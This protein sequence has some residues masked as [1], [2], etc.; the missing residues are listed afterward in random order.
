MEPIHEGGNVMPSPPLPIP[1]VTYRSP[2]SAPSVL[3]DLMYLSVLAEQQIS[4]TSLQS[5][6]SGQILAP[7]RA[8]I[9]PGLFGS[10]PLANLYFYDCG[11]QHLHITGTANVYE[12]AGEILVS[13]LVPFSGIPGLVNA[14]FSV[15]AFRTLQ[16]ALPLIDPTKPLV[17][18]GHSLGGAV[19]QILG[20]FLAQGG[21][22]VSSII[23]LGSPKVGNVTFAAAVS[24]LPVNRYE[25]VGDIVPSV[26][27]FMP[28]PIPGLYAMPVNATWGDYVHGGNPLTVDSLG[29]VTN[30][31]IEMGPAAISLA[32]AAGTIDLHYAYS[33]SAYAKAGWASLPNYAPFAQGYEKPYTMAGLVQPPQPPNT[34]VGPEIAVPA[35]F[36]NKFT[37]QNMSSSG[38]IVTLGTVDDPPPPSYVPPI[39]PI[40]AEDEGCNC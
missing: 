13:Q 16:K 3:A 4:G 14:F 39:I 2:L 31:H 25:L 38:Q 11:P 15:I 34:V 8:V 26:P 20:V 40:P 10:I 35:C 5:A 17:L 23:T 1:G 21:F 9:I 6:L 22:D 32:L 12:L 36:T 37:V 33:Y 28:L 30:E 7:G 19:A 18:S 29:D 24:A 27:Q